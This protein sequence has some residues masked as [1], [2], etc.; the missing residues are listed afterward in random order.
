M[1][2]DERRPDDEAA[3]P[4]PEDPEGRYG[5]DVPETPDAE[6]D[7]WA[8]IPPP[9]WTD[10]ARAAE[11]E[12]RGPRRPAR[13]ATLVA[14]GVV[15]L[16]LLGVVMTVFAVRLYLRQQQ[17][18]ATLAVSVE[19]ISQAYA[20]PG[21]D[22]AT[23]Q[24]VAWLQRTLREGDFAQAREALEG[25]TPPVPGRAGGP[26]QADPLARGGPEPRTP[27]EIPDPMEA[28]DLPQEARSFFAEHDELWKAFFGFT[29]AIVRLERGGAPVEDMQGLRASMV[30][31]ARLGNAERVEEL[32]GNARESIQRLSG[33]ALPDGLQKKLATFTRAFGRAREQGRDVRRAADLAQRS[34][35]AAKAGKFDRAEALLDDAIAALRS[36]PRGRPRPPQM[37]RQG[38]GV[39]PMGP[40]LG[41]L[42]FASELFSNV[43]KSEERDLTVVWDAINNAALAIREH[44][45]DQIREILAKAVDAMHTIGNRRREMGRAIEQAQE[46]ARAARP[47][48]ARSSAEQR[49]RRTQVVMERIGTILAQVRELSAEQYEAARQQITRDL[50]AAVNAPVESGPAPPGEPPTAEERVRA[51]MQIA[52]D[53]LAEAQRRELPTGDLEARFAEARQL[54]VDHEYERAE[55]VVD[56]AVVSLRALMEGTTPSPAQHAPDVIELEDGTPIDLRGIISPEPVTA[57]P[58]AATTAP[59]AP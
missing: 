54:I 16:A 46:Q 51:K 29:V 33:E 45:A 19:R 4:E 15:V 10:E 50:I 39:P 36:A 57:P 43:M 44:N 3:A 17:A 13:A 5:A 32:L 18:M 42:R 28:E 21:A 37:A 58:P 25:L 27:G 55:K 8:E 11:R 2:D 31:A 22:D 6:L 56:E 35:A 9:P 40:D 24:R 49:Q 34:E 30:E 20:G 23:R 52:G 7:E 1:H 59:A 38:R 26:G 53:I 47:A 14:I 48:N 41:F 12:A